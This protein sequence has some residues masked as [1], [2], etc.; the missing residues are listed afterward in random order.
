[1]LFFEKIH[2]FITFQKSRQYTSKHLQLNYSEHHFKRLLLIE[3]IINSLELQSIPEWLLTHHHHH[4]STIESSDWNLVSSYS[5]NIILQLLLW[6]EFWTVRV[7]ISKYIQSW[8]KV[9]SQQM[10][11]TV[12]NAPRHTRPFVILSLFFFPLSL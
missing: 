5:I 7:K 1:M 12:W 9:C 2:R 3:T 10:K 8:S 4:L 6:S 11:A